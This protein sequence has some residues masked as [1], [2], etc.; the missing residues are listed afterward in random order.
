[1]ITERHEVTHNAGGSAKEVEE[2]RTTSLRPG[3][4]LLSIV[5][6]MC[7]GL[8]IEALE[9][10][11]SLALY[12]TYREIAADIGVALILLCLFGLTWWLLLSSLSVGLRFVLGLK[13]YGRDATWYAGVGIPLSYL[14]LEA[15]GA[16]RLGFFPHWHQTLFVW[17]CLG[18]GF[19][20]IS[21]ASIG[22]IGLP[23]LQEFCRTRV[24]PI[25]WLHIAFAVVAF[26]MLRLDG[27]YLF[28]NYA[29]S[30]RA[31]AAIDLP[32]IY[33]VTMDALRAD[34]CS[35]YG[36][37][38]PTTPNLEKFSK[39][40]F[41]FDYFFSNANFTTPATT[42]I[43]TG[44]LPWSHR[45]FQAGGIPSTKAQGETLASVLRQHGYYT[46][47]ITSNYLATPVDHRTL[48]S[49]DA[50]QYF[51]PADSSGYWLR[52]TNLV[53]V[54]TQYTLF[55]SLLKGIGGIRFY[56]GT[57]I[58][59]GYP[60]PPEPVLDRARELA[61]RTDISQPR[62][63]WAHIFPPHDPYLPPARYRTFMAS[64]KLTQTVDFIGFRNTTLPRGVSPS[65]LRA[66]YDEMISYGDNVIGQF[67][68]WLDRTGRLDRSIVIVSA[69]HGESFE[70]GWFLHTGP[71]LNQGLIHI[72]FL[73]HLPHQQKEER[74][75][76][77]AQQAD[78][79]PT[80][81]DLV[82]IM[83]PSWTDGVSLKPV[84]KGEKLGDRLIYSMDLERNSV[85]KAVSAG[86]FAVID[87]EFKYIYDSEKGRESLYNY[88]TD[89]A[90]HQDL[91]RSDPATASRLRNALLGKLRA[92]NEGYLPL[93]SVGADHRR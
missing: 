54:S 21:L 25:A 61:E 7:L 41:V 63:I 11:D 8:E 81:L 51:A 32:D 89:N 50:V 47:M 46:A 30:G 24:A 83:P 16:V 59:R 18:F 22:T 1:M 79:L 78:I 90:E 15:F 56:L 37:S 42:S 27:V 87:E 93:D 29:H 84:L 73:I 62:F 65:D 49:Y 31:A 19:I 45:L 9:Q 68:D 64:D 57:L 2:R 33:L 23:K 17:I 82:S 75:T 86:T 91:S 72:P 66:R 40:S 60:Y 70:D 92:V 88:K 44:Q 39:E 74:I 36:Y 53:G 80:V 67:L 10:I 52:F 71:Y 55:T 34:D 4:L 48:G 28:R 85:F 76:Q 6:I 20:G 69:D 43:E 35:L 14:I 26:V 58:W 12:L 13:T 38:R 5:G 3:L 77:P